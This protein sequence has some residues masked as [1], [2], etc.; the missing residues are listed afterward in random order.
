LIQINM[1]DLA[2]SWGLRRDQLGIDQ[3]MRRRSPVDELLQMRGRST[4]ARLMP[5]T[6]LRH[7]AAEF[8]FH[9]VAPSY[10]DD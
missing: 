7:H 6:A 5:V 4:P 3:Q 1:A 10:K 9:Y 2:A 8:A